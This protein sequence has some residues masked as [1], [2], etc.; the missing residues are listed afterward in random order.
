MKDTEN[1]SKAVLHTCNWLPW[2]KD[3]NWETENKYM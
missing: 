3:R 2:G 1:I